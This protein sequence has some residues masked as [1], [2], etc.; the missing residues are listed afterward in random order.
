MIDHR[1]LG[2]GV[3][4]ILLHA[5]PLSSQMWRRQ[6]EALAG[7]ARVILPDLPGLGNSPRQAEPSIPE[8]AKEVGRLLD[9]LKIDESVFLAGLSMGG[10]VAFEFLRRFPNRV[11]GLGLFS[12]RA[13]ADT[14]ETKDRRMK[15]IEAIR[16]QGLVPFAE[17]T[18]PNL[19]GQSTI[20]AKP[21]VVEEVREMV[22]KNK[23]DGVTDALLAMAERRDAADLLPDIT[24]PAIVIAGDEDTVVP[25]EEAQRMQRAIPGSQFHVIHR[26]GHLVNLE[27]PEVFLNLLQNFLRA[28]VL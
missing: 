23:P 21:D 7:P 26:A 28:N 27:Q 11:R 5:F 15:T 1:T 25:L 3:P 10:Y 24:C 12:T 19:L 6:A 22:L 13:S 18:I 16:S 17:K 8:M 20:Q 9:R 14:P 4:I 2:N